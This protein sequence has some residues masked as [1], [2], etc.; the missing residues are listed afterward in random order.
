MACKCTQVEM[1]LKII[2][3]LR[4]TLSKTNIVP[5][6]RFGKEI[7]IND[8]A[9]RQLFFSVKN[10]VDKPPDCLLHKITPDD[11]EGFKKV[12]DIIDAVIEEFECTG[13]E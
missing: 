12:A 13:G 10:A 3:A 4:V 11:F 1:E 2:T 6:S 8:I 5:G 7:R 9:K